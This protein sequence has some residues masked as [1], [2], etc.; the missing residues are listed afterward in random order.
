VRASLP[1]WF[2][3]TEALH[4]TGIAP[5]TSQL[6]Y[7]VEDSTGQLVSATL[8]SLRLDQRNVT[9]ASAQVDTPL[10]ERRR[11][12]PLWFVPLAGDSC[13]YACF[14]EYGQLAKYAHPM[15]EYVDHHPVST[16]IID[17]RRNGG[18][19][20]FTGRHQLVGPARK[21]L[22]SGKL[23]NLYVLIGNATFSAAMVNAID[24]RKQCH[25]TLIGEPIGERPN[26]YSERRLTTLPNSKL[27]VTYSVRYYKFQNDDDPQTV[28]PD[29]TIE[30]TWEEYRAARDPVLEWA[31]AHR[32]GR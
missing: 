7:T 2:S 4:D 29:V 22:A 20:F 19:N 28:M 11:N 8:R 26:S 27:V 5:D 12:A 25:A 32:S 15:W 31:L 23:R 6:S 3:I 21:R 18:G 16:V 24:F 17:L 9:P 30:P 14:T 13:V 10:Y 1:Q